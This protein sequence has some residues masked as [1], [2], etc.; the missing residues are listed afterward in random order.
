MHKSVILFIIGLVLMTPALLMLVV[1]GC[2][3]IYD[4]C[5]RKVQDGEWADFAMYFFYAGL[6][7]I[8]VAAWMATCENSMGHLDV[9]PSTNDTQ[10]IQPQVE[11]PNQ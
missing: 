5:K 6:A 4:F 9:T 1:G 8:V 2:I 10:Q 3:I 11:N 7:S